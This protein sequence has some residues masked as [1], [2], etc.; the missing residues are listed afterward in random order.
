[1]VKGDTFPTLNET[2]KSLNTLALANF[3]VPGDPAFPLSAM[4]EK[5]KDRTEA[6]LM[7]QYLSQIRQ[8]VAIRLP[9]RI[10]AA[11]YSDTEGGKKPSKWWMSFQKRKFMNKAL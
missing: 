5:P 4:Y 3:A 10:Y 11:T 1:M 9:E 8:E 2:L 7:K 6:D